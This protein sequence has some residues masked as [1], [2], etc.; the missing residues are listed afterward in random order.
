MPERKEKFPA[1]FSY[2]RAND[3]HDR[4]KLTDLRK[5]LQNEIWAQTG[6]PFK[7][8]QDTESI[9][10]GNEWKL[11]ITDALESSSLLLAIV[12]PSYLLSQSCRFEFEY[13][14]KRESRL[15]QKLILP[16]IYIETP[17][18]NDRNDYIATEISKRQWVDW[19]DLRFSSLTSTKVS[20]KLESLAKQ[21]RELLDETRFEDVTAKTKSEYLLPESVIR[22]STALPGEKSVHTSEKVPTLYTP[23]F[24]LG[25]ETSSPLQITILLRQTDDPERNKRRLKILYS[26]LISC[27]GWDKFSFQILE[28]GKSHL[29]DFPHDTTRV[30]PELLTRL[31][32][33]M[34][35]ESW[36]IEEINFR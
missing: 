8:F 20:K 35:E 27:K 36:R 14:L 33:L 29:I 7:I 22:K 5:A 18:L 24:K 32:N 16:I 15:N 3:K 12:T 17:K 30:G 25:E 28:R 1:F 6:E 19:K 4:G 21:I 23:D 9:E 31:K 10:W 11:R 26:T 13:F 34:G 2:V